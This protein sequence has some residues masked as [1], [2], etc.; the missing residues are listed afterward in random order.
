MCIALLPARVS[1]AA[2]GLLGL[3]REA[4]M[5][6]TPRTM[7]HLPRLS[8]HMTYRSC[9]VLRGSA[10]DIEPEQDPTPLNPRDHVCRDGRILRKPVHLCISHS[11]SNTVKDYGGEVSIDRYMRLPVEQ[12]SMLNES[13][14]TRNPNDPDKFILQ[15][16]PLSILSVWIQ[17]SVEVS[18][19]TLEDRVELKAANCHIDGSNTII[20]MGLDKRFEFEAISTMQWKSD[21]NLAEVTMSGSLNVWCEKLPPFNLMPTA[22]LQSAS[23]AVLRAAIITIQRIFMKNLIKDYEIWVNMLCLMRCPNRLFI[24]KVLFIKQ[25]SL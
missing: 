3:S 12:Y 21:G 22:I 23:N 19:E 2:R 16:P 7:M 9:P 8:S 18:V 24:I 13:L 4:I 25:E 17:P 10:G 11:K 15:V 20:K 1:A 6:R 5:T 14:I